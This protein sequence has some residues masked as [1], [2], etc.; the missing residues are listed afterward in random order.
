MP[1]FF[2]KKDSME[3]AGLLF[4]DLPFNFFL[5]I[6]V[7]SVNLFFS[8]I[9]LINLFSVNFYY[10][11]SL[12]IVELTVFGSSL[13]WVVCC[14]SFL[15]VLFEVFVLS[16]ARRRLPCWLNLLCL[17]G[18]GVVLFS[19]IDGLAALFVFPLSFAIVGLLV[20]FGLG[21]YVRRSE[22]FVFVSLG[23]V[24]LL[25]FF[26]AASLVTWVWNVFDYSFPFV[27]FS[28]WKF[29]LLDLNLFSVFYSWV[30]WLFIALFFSWAWIPLWKRVVAKF[31]ALGDVFRRD[32]S[33][34]YLSSLR[35][36]RRTLIVCLVA[37]VGIAIFVSA[38]PY[39]N[40][41]GS[42]LVGSDSAVYFK[43]MED[44][45]ESG[46]GV[47]FQTDRP[48]SNLL[49]YVVQFAFGL[50]SDLVVKV[51]PV[52]CCVGLSLVVFWFVRVGL[53][54]DV[55]GLVS[56]FFSIVSFHT[57]VGIYAYSV[58][59]WLALIWVFLMFGLVLKSSENRSWAYVFA[60]S[61]FGV[62][63]LF[64]HPY[65]W[66]VIMVVLLAYLVWLVLRF[67]LHRGKEGKLDILQIVSVLSVNFL[68]YG[69]Y[70]V[71]PFGRAVTS[72]GLGFVGES[73]V[74]PNI[75]GFPEGVK[76]SV[77]MWVGGLFAN[78][79]LVFLAV[80]GMFSVVALASRFSRVLLLWVMVPSLALLLVSS[81]NYMFYRIFYLIPFQVL[82]TMGVFWVFG[83]IENRFRLNGSRIYWLFKIAFLL[84]VF[85]VL[86]NY[87]LRSVDG[88]PLHLW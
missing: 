47:A 17:G 54:N 63:L 82:A 59:N 34:G 15:A 33:C 74:F 64:T 81:E 2:S 67:Y 5:L 69:I 71:L 50:S 4:Q 39:F 52:I 68:V 84:L 25:L 24:S 48:L 40:R 77:E 22:G 36:P 51:M 46:F 85:F 32:G 1:S 44:M 60:G 14:G 80:L 58:S 55:L 61:L 65:T 88:A 79:L 27:E 87:A 70:S 9:S 57:T 8:L 30:P 20:Y 41:S 3:R 76:T 86:M 10:F 16:F 31:A 42:S 72:G 21:Y 78:P 62:F 53:H 7:L 13:D 35:L 38:Y 83:F 66:D 28:R 6:F 43:W 12:K 56:G 11:Y 26:S 18:L 49:M 23:L 19:F 29:A 75:L 73:I 37:L 45:G